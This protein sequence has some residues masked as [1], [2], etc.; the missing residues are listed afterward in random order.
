MQKHKKILTSRN[1]S[2]VVKDLLLRISEQFKLCRQI[3]IKITL[4]GDL[5]CDIKAQNDVQ[6]HPRTAEVLK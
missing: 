6:K 4:L 5:F 3:G 1:N 2:K